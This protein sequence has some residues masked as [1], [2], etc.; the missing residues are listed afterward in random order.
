[1]A[2]L[3]GVSI[4]VVDD[5]VDNRDMPGGKLL[6][7]G[8][9]ATCVKGSRAAVSAALTGLYD[10]VVMDVARDGLEATAALRAAGF[11]RPII[12][13]TANPKFTGRKLVKLGFDGLVK[14]PT[15]PGTLALCISRQLD[16][17]WKRRQRA[18]SVK[19][20]ANEVRAHHAL[21]SGR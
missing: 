14:I 2:D 18:L 8:A 16:K 15:S 13:C 1:M 10:V 11:T 4:L 7:S 21:S 5:A 9:S 19:L 6:S 3:R 12:V 17:A 20:K